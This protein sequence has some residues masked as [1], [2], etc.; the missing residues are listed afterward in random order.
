[1]MNTQIRYRHA[2]F[3]IIALLSMANG[4]GMAVL[5][6]AFFITFFFELMFIAF[7]W[8]GTLHRKERQEKDRLKAAAEASFA[9]E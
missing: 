6:Q 8:A 3:F 2:L 4:D 7:R 1:M 5:I 9:R